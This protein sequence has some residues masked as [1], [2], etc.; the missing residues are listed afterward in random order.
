MRRLLFVWVVL[1][2]SRGAVAQPTYT[3]ANQTVND[4]R[5]FFEDTG[6]N[7]IAPG[8]YGNNEN[9]IFR[10]INPQATQIIF[11]FSTF[12]L[13]IGS[14]TLFFYDGPNIN[15]PLIG[16][17]SGIIRP[18]AIVALS[19]AL[20]IRF[21]SDL[22]ITCTGWEAYWTTIVPPPIPPDM[23]VITAS[24]N[25]NTIQIQLDTLVHCDSVYASAFVLAGGQGQVVTA[26]QAL[27]CVGD[28]TSNI[29]LTVDLP[30]TS[31]GNY[32]LIWN[33]NVL[34]VCDSLYTFLLNG[35]FSITDCPI[36]AL[37]T[38]NDDSLCV[39]ECFLLTAAGDGGDCNYTYTWLAGTPGLNG[40]GP[41]LICLNSTTTFTVVVDDGSPTPPDTASITI[42]VTTPPFA[43]NDT[44]VCDQ[45]AAF[46]L[47]PL[48]NP[49]GGVFFGP[50]IT[51]AA[52]GTFNPGL[53]GPGIHQVFYSFNGCPDTLVITV[54]GVTPGLT[55][56]SCPGANP[57]QLT[58]NTP[59]GG[60]WS[61]PNV[62]PGGLYTPPP[63]AGVDTLYYNF[64]NCSLPRLIFVD[65]IAMIKVDT[66]CQSGGI[67]TLQA[68]P[69]GGLW[70]G[71]GIIDNNAGTFAP[72]LTTAGNH[73][74][75]YTINGCVDTLRMHIRAMEAGNNLTICPLSP[76]FNV[77]SGIPAGGWWFGPGITDSIA[78]TFNP[79]VNGTGNS[80]IRLFYRTDE[81]QDSITVFLT[82]TNIAPD[83]LRRCITGGNLSLAQGNT[84][85]VPNGGVWSGSGVNPVGNGTFQ[86]AVAGTGFHRLFYT[87]AGCADSMVVFVSPLPVA[88]VDTV[89]CI[90]QGN[91]IFTGTPSGGTWFGP[92]ILSVSG[93][94]FN[95]GTAGIGNHRLY[96]TTAAGCV[97]SM[98]VQVNSLPVPSFNN[99]NTIYCHIDSLFLLNLTPVGGILSGPGCIGGSFNPVLAGMGLHQLIYS[100]GLGL[101]ERF[102]TL[103][104]QV[105]DSL[106]IQASGSSDTLCYGDTVLLRV[107]K[108]GG[109]LGAI[110][111]WANLGNGDSI[112]FVPTVSGWHPVVVSDGCS[113]PQTDS[114][115]V[116][117]HS[118][119]VY[120]LSQELEN[121]YDSLGT[122]R[123]QY[124]PGS[125]YRTQWYTLPN[126]F[127]DTLFAKQGS[128]AVRITDTLTGCYL[129]DTIVMQ[130]F[131]V[132]SANFTTNPNQ[133]CYDLA[134][135]TLTFI[136]L[137]VGGSSG[138]WDFGDGIN[139]AY[140]FGQYPTHTFADTG[141]FVVELVIF[142]ADGCRSVHRQVI[143]VQ[144]EPKI[145]VPT[146][147]TPNG[148]GLNE[149]FKVESIGIRNFRI[150]LYNRWGERVFQAADKTFLWDGR[151]KG[152]LVESGVYPF[153]II[154]TDYLSSL[155]KSQKGVLHLLR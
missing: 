61:G 113:T 93:G 75:I 47:S 91:L 29:R 2:C 86:P 50:G 122:Y 65:S 138:N 40:P 116:Y 48:A 33:F 114:V 99:S 11:T 19:G 83:T 25:T 1:L 34:D 105:R 140:V 43:G 14:D 69:R 4:C 120:T 16:A 155:P 9:F 110:S 38:A 21:V 78:G 98:Q 141:R 87:A 111:S 26:A 130:S 125:A 96:Y 22:S 102:D 23:S 49:P 15:S 12:C 119:I 28:S 131:P 148:D 5:A 144:V 54:A 100:A 97:D 127:G 117:V 20:T 104:V 36:T 123:I 67:D 81:C 68:T 3:M 70:S 108:T 30:F 46:D 151:Y 92:G 59:P 145:Y 137:S 18:P 13:E 118:Q 7:P 76:P 126:S 42:L 115:F 112:Y 121:C 147:F 72:Y 24:C 154:Y 32:N 101:C 8:N 52:V 37:L 146:A 103:L 129:L 136:D 64:A 56:A 77:P 135:S 41:H 94:L 45:S 153:V 150:E 143:C 82:R 149:F 44:L 66:T 133:R 90:N 84:G 128:Y 51:A 88:P 27:N 74:L 71:P 79:G 57:I 139:E 95:T 58:G 109:L 53:A 73:L 134:S 63:A 107:T 152:E 55:L 6:N 142:S 39:D 89:V 60:T 80:S 85:R 31:C 17:F 10:I 132:I 124:A 35:G 106:R 62:T